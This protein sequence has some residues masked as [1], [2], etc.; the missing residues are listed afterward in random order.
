RLDFGAPL[1]D[2]PPSPAAPHHKTK[3]R[4][5]ARATRFSLAA[6]INPIRARIISGLI[7]S[8]PIVITFWIVYWIFMTLEHYLL[9]PLAGV[10]NRIRAWMRDYPALQELDL[11]DW[12]YNVGSPVLAIV[13]ALAILYILGLIL[14]S[15]VYRTLEWFLLHVPIVATIYRA[16]RSLVESL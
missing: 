1:M 7:F 11:P 15:W 2:R 14:R 9:N 6:I 5:P 3:G 12:W 4:A 10:I 16:V 13:L 8:L